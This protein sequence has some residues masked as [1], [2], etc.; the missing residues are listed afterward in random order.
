MGLDLPEMGV[1]GYAP[2]NIGQGVPVSHA[3]TTGPVGS[4]STVQAMQAPSA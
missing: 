1:E 2:G 4:P 3:P